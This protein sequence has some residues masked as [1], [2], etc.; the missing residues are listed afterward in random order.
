[1]KFGQN[2]RRGRC[3]PETKHETEVQ[4]ILPLQFDDEI[5]SFLTRTRR[6]LLVGEI[7]EISSTYICSHL[8]MLACEKKPIYLYINSV[9]GCL[10]S[11]YAIIDQMLA[12]DCPVHTIVRGQAQSMG[13]LIAAFGE[14]GYRYS[15]PNSLMMLHSILIQSPSE[16]IEKHMAM[17]NYIH[18]DYRE[19]I[20][21]LAKRLKL[22]SKELLNAMDDTQWMSPKQAIAV[23]MI[24]KIWTPRME[25]AVNRELKK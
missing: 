18:R 24:D 23:G 3:D 10:S 5:D 21:N 1:M 19:K 16:P 12:C 15:T 2:R 17:M 14:K 25:R 22:T 20:I 4:P 11:G 8:Q 13:A 7:D 6:L 9:G